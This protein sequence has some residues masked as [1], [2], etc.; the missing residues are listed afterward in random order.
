[1][2]PLLR[3]TPTKAAFLF[4]V[5]KASGMPGVRRYRLGRASLGTCCIR[6]ALDAL[7]WHCVYDIAVGQ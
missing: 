5:Y 4:S 2:M 3:D 1:M 7:L 6:L